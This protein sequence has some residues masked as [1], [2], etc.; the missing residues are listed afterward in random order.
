MNP[1]GV[2][3]T[4]VNM[5]SKLVVNPPIYLDHHATTPC[6]PRVVEAMLPTFS[7]QF[8]NAA[9]RQHAFGL[10]AAKL[11]EAARQQV[12]SLIHCDPRE[13]I[14]TSGATES[15]NLAIKGL[16][17][18]LGESDCHVVTSVIEHKAVLDSCQSLEEK[19]V[20]VTYVGV[21][22]DGCVR[23]EELEKALRPQTRLVSIQFA[24]NEIG[25]VQPVREIGRSCRERGIRFHCDA[26]QALPHLPCDVDDLELDLLSLSA[27]KMYGPKGIGALYVRRK[28]PR[29][30]LRPLIDGGGHERGLRSGTLNVPGIVG[31]GK[32]CE[33][34][35]QERAADASR[36]SALRDRLKDGLLSA[37]G[38]ITINGSL[39][40]RLPNNL[41]V[42]FL[43]VDSEKLIKA[44]NGLAVSS[45]A[46]CS[47]A[48]RDSS[49]VLRAIGSGD[50]ALAGSVRFGVGRFNTEEEIDR[51]ARAVADAVREL[52]SAPGLV[53]PAEACRPG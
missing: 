34:V 3:P 48:S 49:Y 47:S 53:G 8:G 31:F 2:W 5:P 51:A 4:I 39:D 29:V 20:E 52:R 7:D 40:R 14:F 19:G 36:A 1:R 21:G 12:A 28:S 18:Q 35:R 24:N 32:A 11:V 15:N 16:V 50:L 38:E 41:N 17:E 37:I 23:V 33:L 26:V 22:P 13:V 9:S 43:G 25:T 6:D 27:H 42:S 45:G 10:D 44:L 30:R 46:A